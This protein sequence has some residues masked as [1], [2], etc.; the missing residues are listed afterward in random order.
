[1]A[2]IFSAPFIIALIGFFFAQRPYFTIRNNTETHVETFYGKIT[3]ALASEQHF[4]AVSSRKLGPVN[5]ILN[6]GSSNVRIRNVLVKTFVSLLLLSGDISVNPGPC[7][8]YPCGI[9]GKPVK[10]NQRGIQCDFCEVWSHIRCLN[11]NSIV[12]E[13]LAN[14]S[15][16]WECCSCGMP[17]FSSS[18]LDSFSNIQCSNQFSSL[19]NTSTNSTLGSPLLSS[20]PSTRKQDQRNKSNALSILTVNCQ[21][22]M[23][24]KHALAQLIDDAKPDIIVATE[25]WL[26]KNHGTGELLMENYEIERRD[27]KSDPHGGVLLAIKKDLIATREP[28]LETDCEILWCK[29]KM[30]GN[31]TIH[32]GSYYRPHESDENSLVELEKSLGK[33]KD[34]H[35]V[36]LAGDFNFPGWDWKEHIVRHC[37]YPTLHH[38]FGE[39]LD[40]ENLTQLIELPTRGD[41]TLDLVLTNFPNNVKNTSVLPGISDHDCPLVSFDLKPIRY[42]QKP[43]NIPIYSKARWESLREELSVAASNLEKDSDTKS[44][45]ELWMDFK[46]AITRG[47][48]NHIPHKIC[49]PKDNLPWV[50]PKIRQLIKKR[51]RLSVRRKLRMKAGQT[52]PNKITTKIKA[53]KKM[54]QKEMRDAYWRYVESIITPEEHTEHQSCNKRF[55]TF[56]KHCRTD[57]FGIKSLCDEGKE[58]TKPVDIANALNNQ[59]KSVFTAETPPTCN[60]LPSSHYPDMENIQITEAGVLKLLQNLKEHKAC[61]PDNIKPKVLKEMANIVAPMLTLIFKKSYDCGEVPEDWKSA[62]VTPIFKAGTKSDPANYRPI[63]LTCVACKLMEHIITSAIMK[64]TKRHNIFYHLQHG[65]REGLSCV[66]QLIEVVNDL[67][68]NMQGGGQTDLLIMDFSKAFDRVG[69]QR[70]LLKLEHYGVRHKTHDWIRSFLSSRNQ[71]VVVGGEFSNIVQVQSGVPQGSALAPCLFL[72]FINDLPNQLDSTVRLFADDTLLYLAVQSHKDTRT[73]QDDLRK[74][75]DWEKK[76]QMDFNPSKCHVLRVTRKREPIVYDY[77]L[78]GKVLENVDASKYLGITLSSDLR[79]N[80]HVSNISNKGN[81]ILGFLRRNLKINS[82]P[83][84]TLAYKTL[85]RPVLEYAAEAWDPYTKG[86]IYTLEMVQR[87]AA[88]FVLNRQ[89]NT[90]SVTEMLKELNW[91]T[92]EQRRKKLRLLMFY[93]LHTKEITVDTTKYLVPRQHQSRHVND[94]PYSIPLARTD[95]YKYSFFPRTIKD[96][97]CLPTDTVNSGSPAIFM[98]KLFA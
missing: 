79:W 3:L 19:D 29:L 50:T 62:Y 85:V 22:I 39:L 2:D 83:I 23:A 54:I 31:K 14:S 66:T 34:N 41:K 55:W 88:R 52:D 53:L 89:H 4:Q 63:S 36:L 17:N 48:K 76:W 13:A 64:H 86:D 38:R 49:K 95:S 74:L 44:V 91:E 71:R 94:H 16:V 46:V 59:F 11:M 21:S 61:G 37:N 27:R 51:D 97:N 98:A 47:V 28:E 5:N 8:K 92:L 70:L 65:F 7:Y 32:V 6:H 80:P 73:L 82:P 87:R 10:L 67:A 30:Q 75:E 43:R 12:Y 81:Q 33:I 1:M 90:S 57:S 56:I 42:R 18:L 20:S 68:F 69:H 93:K 58:L 78:H 84:K 60:L 25:T 72:L 45:N 26:T 96:W 35:Q 40:D 9:C 15:C 77:V 24:K